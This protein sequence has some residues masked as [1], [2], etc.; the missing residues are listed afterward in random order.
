M[1]GTV[2]KHVTV[3][4]ELSRLVNEYCLLDVSELEQDFTAQS[5][6]TAALQVSILKLL[7]L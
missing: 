3:I 1:S 4:S 5:D 6:H 2:T 7:L